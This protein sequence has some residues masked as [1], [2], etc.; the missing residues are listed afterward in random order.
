MRN[1]NDL[2]PIEKVKRKNLWGFRFLALIE[3]FGG[4]IYV[5]VYPPYLLAFTGSI[6]LTGVLT[7]LG[8]IFFFFPMPLIGKLSDRYGRKKIFLL[9]CPNIILG[10]FVI[11]IASNIIIL[12]IGI[13]IL[14]IGAC[15]SNIGINILISESS[16]E[17]KK[18]SNFGL[19]A[20]GGLTGGILGKLFITFGL[21]SNIRL[22]FL[23]HIII[24]SFLFLIQIFVLTEPNQVNHNRSSNP[25]N[26][27]N[28]RESIW[29]KVLSN[30][31]TKAIIIFFTLDGFIF[32]ISGAL[33]ISGLQDYYHITIENIAFIIVWNN[34]SC[35][36]FQIPAGYIIDKI[37][38]RKSLIVS[39]IFGIGYFSF[40]LLGFVI[41]NIGFRLFLFLFL[42]IAEVFMGIRMSMF[43]PAL[44]IS[45]TNLDE[46]GNRRAESY[47]IATLIRGI[48]S[49]PTG[50]IAGLLIEYVHYTAPFILSILGIL[51]LIWILPKYF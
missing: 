6:F 12:I 32:G 33:Y 25:S 7:T 2:S 5:A 19:T 51:L 10:F 30:S 48:G 34:I 38:K 18:G 29:K 46:V 20:F 50:I 16:K 35:M 49:I 43:V 13:I 45:L 21:F 27:N 9:G 11:I 36:V 14:Y 3:G 28:H 22:Y 17:T 39:Q 26:S 23:I 4:G 31:K 1:I 15:F 8:G 44:G 40:I 47:G 37:G 42:T 41:W 24:Y